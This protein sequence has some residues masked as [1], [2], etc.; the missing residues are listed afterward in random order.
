MAAALIDPLPPMSYDNSTISNGGDADTE[1]DADDLMVRVPVVR[2]MH[3][4]RVNSF[5]S[6]HHIPRGSGSK[7]CQGLAIRCIVLYAT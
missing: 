5:E 3:G 7:F 6:L 1:D 4:R 2:G